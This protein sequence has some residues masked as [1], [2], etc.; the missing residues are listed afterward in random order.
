M[1]GTVSRPL[2]ALAIAVVTVALALAVSMAVIAVTGGHARGAMVALLDGAFGSRGQVAGTIAKTIPLTLVALG[3]IVAFSARRIN[4]GFE[5]Q[6]LAGGIV[7]TV[8]GLKAEFLPA[9]LHLGAAVAGATLAGALYAGVAAWLWATRGVNEIISTLMLNFAA[10]QLVSWLVR[11]PLQEPT[12]TFPRSATIPDT[13]LWP[14]IIPHTSFGW[15]LVLALVAV[16]AVTVMLWR[17]PL[18]F[19]IRLTGANER[20]ARLAGVATTRITVIAL[21]VSGGLA[22][23]AG[24]SVILGGETASMADNFSANYGFT[25]IVAALLAR[26][27][28]PATVPA[29][30]LFAALRQGGGLMEARVGVSSA[31]VLVT[32]SIVIL[33]ISAAGFLFER[34]RRV[35][36]DTAPTEPQP[37]TVARVEVRDGAV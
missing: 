7:A 2:F 14:R 21:M 36:V 10:I 33:L 16:A 35:R 1:R 26:N 22:G 13:A 15:D 9:P 28:P 6:I 8:I 34:S 3:W 5:G 25:G 18:G 27:S 31:L 11:G 19:Q 12:R 4:I 23:L 37:T 32:Q 29:A 17:T 30:L 20:A 24:S